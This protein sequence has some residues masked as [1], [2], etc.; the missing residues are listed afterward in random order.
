MTLYLDTAGSFTQW[1]GEPLD[2]IRYPMNI[3]Q[4]WT[5][6]ELAAINLYIPA[7]PG[8]PADK[9]VASTKVE[10]IDGVVTYVYTLEDKQLAEDELHP[11]LEPWK[12]WAALALNG[13]SKE[14]IV[15]AIDS[16]DDPEAVTFKVM[17]KAKLDH[18]PGGLFYR[19][20]PLFHNAFLQMQLHMTGEEIDAVWDAAYDFQ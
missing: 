15:A 8:I 13:I 20:D 10:R 3:E 4:L 2:S 17:A 16:I 18:P 14:Q 1:L 7:Q 5:A 11:P 19:S 9:T 12:F 6:E